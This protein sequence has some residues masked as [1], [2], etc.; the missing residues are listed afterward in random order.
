MKSLQCPKCK[1]EK[2]EYNSLTYVYI[3]DNCDLWIY[4]E[5]P[6]EIYLLGKFVVEG[7]SIEEC[8]RKYKLK[9]LS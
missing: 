2:A 6:F 9:V 7:N 8:I 3:C 5:K 4:N 1:E